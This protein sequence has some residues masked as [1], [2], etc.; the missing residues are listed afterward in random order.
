LEKRP[1]RPQN[2]EKFRSRK[3]GVQVDQIHSLIQGAIQAELDDSVKGTVEDQKKALRPF[4]EKVESAQ[5]NV[6]GLEK[7]VKDVKAEKARMYSL[8]LFYRGLSGL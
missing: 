8:E 6:D 7:Q 2:V 3:N 5:T 1:R 4:S